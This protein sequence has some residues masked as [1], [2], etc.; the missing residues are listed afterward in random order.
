MSNNV[1]PNAGGKGEIEQKLEGFVDT[2]F[3]RF[4][5]NGEES[6]MSRENAEILMQ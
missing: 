1:G 6:T 5:L 3:K 4:N 2:S